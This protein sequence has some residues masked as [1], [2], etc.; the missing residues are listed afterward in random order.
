M[1]DA[2]QDRAAAAARRDRVFL[3]VVDDSPERE[4]AL[5]FACLR[6]R[7]GGGR[8]ALLRVVE[9]VGFSFWAGVGARMEAERR[10]EAERLLA[11]LAAEVLE[12]AGSY[13][14]LLIREG[15]PREALLAQVEEDPRI[16]VLVL[17][18]AAASTGPGPLIAALTGRH[19][20]RLL[21]PMTVV[22]GTLDDAALDRVTRPRPRSASPAL[23]HR[24]R[25]RTAPAR[26]GRRTGAGARQPKGEKSLF[27]DE[28][29]EKDTTRSPLL[30]K[31]TTE[32]ASSPPAVSS[33]PAGKIGRPSWA[34][35]AR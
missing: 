29:E 5:K 27:E 16:S 25:S 22:P 33:E 20:G 7:K 15:E 31:V 10:E 8:V 12:V 35:K 23:H 11:G 2:E 13:P 32:L 30:P 24:R 28:D 17:A 21:V 14:I 9:P 19:A 4:V 26:R 18:S 34:P 3:V 1:G 6:A